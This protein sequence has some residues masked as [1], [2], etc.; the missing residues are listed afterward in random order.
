MDIY[1]LS[2]IFGPNLMKAK[3]EDAVTMMADAVHVQ[4]IVYLLIEN[5]G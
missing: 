5:H 4:H 2:M 1:N 3:K